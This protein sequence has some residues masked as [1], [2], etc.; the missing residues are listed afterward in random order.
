[1]TNYEKVQI[2]ISE[3]KKFSRLC[4][5][6]NVSYVYKRDGI[7]RLIRP[8]LSCVQKMD[9]NCH[10][11]ANAVYDCMTFTVTQIHISHSRSELEPGPSCTSYVL[12]SMTV[13][14]SLHIFIDNTVIR[15]GG[16]DRHA[17]ADALQPLQV[18][19]GALRS[20][21]HRSVPLPIL[22]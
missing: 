16:E 15:S 22:S 18:S 3:P 10:A 6:N 12:Q 13:H 1:M 5:F 17:P 20:L 21:P 8:W 2:S 4:T 7:R 11:P 9:Q 19:H 14:D